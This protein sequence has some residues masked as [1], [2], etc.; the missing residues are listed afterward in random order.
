MPQLDFHEFM[1]TN[2][3]HVRDTGARAVFE[4]VGLS[5][6]IAAVESIELRARRAAG[7]MLKREAQGI[8]SDAQERWIPIDTGRAKRS[9]FVR[10]PRFSGDTIEVDLGFGPVFNERGSPYILPLHEIPEPPSKSVGGR[11]ATHQHGSWKFL[12]IPF[13]MRIQ[14]MENRLGQEI[15]DALTGTTMGGMADSV[16]SGESFGMGEF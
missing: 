4:L 2:V 13:L 14:D 8:I 12:Q 6:V 9:G 15:W 3:T 7:N 11:S 10:G 16:M 1:D 5:Q